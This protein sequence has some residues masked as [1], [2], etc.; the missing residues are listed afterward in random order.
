MNMYDF[1][2]RNNREMGVLIEESNDEDL[3]QEAITE[4]QSI[5]R[6]SDQIKTNKNLGSSGKN[7][8]WQSRGL[9]F[10]IRC[11]SR[12]EYKPD[13]PYCMECFLKW[14][15]FEN[16]FYTESVCHQCGEYNSSSMDKPECWSCYSNN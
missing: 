3:Y 5:L 4:V 1:S 14:R 2:E 6:L 13:Q 9:G 8:G 12:I 7:N 16:P 11:E 15:Q 10:C